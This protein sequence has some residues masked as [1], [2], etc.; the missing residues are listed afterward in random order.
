M[1]IF[2]EG[3]DFATGFYEL[4]YAL[5]IGERDE[6]SIIWAYDELQNILNV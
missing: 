4:C 2:D 1:R 3:Q 5:A 6:K